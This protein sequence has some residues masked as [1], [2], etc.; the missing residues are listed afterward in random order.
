MWR[1]KRE[2]KRD[3][4][5]NFAAI[6]GFMPEAFLT[7]VIVL[8]GAYFGKK[9]DSLERKMRILQNKRKNHKMISLCVVFA[10]M[11]LAVFTV[12]SPTSIIAAGTKNS[13]YEFNVEKS[14]DG[15]E[16][17]IVGR[18]SKDTSA[19]EVKEIIGPDGESF[20]PDKVSYHVTQNGIYDFK[21]NYSS[22]TG[23]K[24]EKISVS[25]E[26]L[27]PPQKQIMVMDLKA[28]QGR[29]A[30][31]IDIPMYI[32]G[33]T[34]PREMY[35]F[36]GG[37]IK[38]IP[39]QTWEQR[40]YKFDH[41]EIQITEGATVKTYPISYYD[42]IDGIFYYAVAKDGVPAQDFDV[43]YEAPPD[44][45]VAFVYSLDTKEYTVTL[46]ND[47]K[48]EGFSVD[49]L[50]GIKTDK[51][52]NYYA[53]SMAPVKVQLTYPVGYYV[54]NAPEG[55]EAVGISFNFDDPALKPEVSSDPK[56]RIVTYAFNYPD[57]AVTMT[58]VGDKQTTDLT[59][60][61]D[62]GSPGFQNWREQGETMWTATDADGNYT[63]S[64]TRYG[65]CNNLSER[66]FDMQVL[67]GTSTPITVSSGATKNI[68]TG[69]FNSGQELDFEYVSARYMTGEMPFFMWPSPTVNFCYFPNGEDYSTGTPI[70]ETIQIWD[71]GWKVDP[72]DPSGFPPITPEPYIAG[73][74]AKITVTV[75]K[76]IVTNKKENTSL[77]PLTSY[78][79]YKV[80]VKIENMKNSFY[81]RS[82]S[83][84]SVQGP[85]Y[86]RD[87]ESISP[88]SVNGVYDSY[89]VDSDTQNNN[90]DG[91]EDGKISPKSIAPGGI[92]LDKLALYN[93]NMPDGSRVPWAGDTD[94]FFQFKIAPKW[95]Y[96]NP[97]I[98]S[99]GADST[100]IMTNV[101]IEIENEKDKHNASLPLGSYSWFNPNQNRKDVSS[102]Q[103]TMFMP[104]SS[105]TDRHDLRAI[106]VKTDKITVDITNNGTAPNSIVE[107]GSNGTTFD[108]LE[109]DK[110]IFNPDYKAS[111]EEGKTFVGF[112]GEITAPDNELLPSDYKLLLAKSLDNTVYFRPGDV[113]SLSDYFRRDA[114][115]LLDSWNNNKTLSP[116][117][118]ERLNLLMYSGN[119]KVKFNLIYKDGTSSEGEMLT[120]KVNKY[121]QDVNATDTQY[122]T[123]A[124]DTK[125][126]DIIAGSKITFT[127]FAETHENTADHYTYYHNTQTS[128]AK[129]EITTQGEELA[130]VKYDRGLTVSYLNDNK[131]P[132]EGIS[133]TNVYR[134]YDGSNKAAIK[135]PTVA[136][137]PPGKAFDHWTVEELE[138]NGQWTQKQDLKLSEGESP[139]VYDFSSG[140]GANNKSIRLTAVW[141]DI[142]PE[143][144]VSIPMNIVLTEN[145]TNLNDP[146]QKHAGSGVTISY[147][148]VYGNDKTVNVDVLKAFN[149]TSVNDASKTVAVS[150]CNADGSS[151]S[152]TAEDKY[153]NVALLGPSGA[154]GAVQTKKLWFN[155]VSQSGN[156]VYKGTFN[157][158]SSLAAGETPL[159][160]ISPG[161]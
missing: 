103:Y 21:V 83:S 157:A 114:A 43:A 126:V 28:M 146:A 143:Y 135:F 64:D 23:K 127:N 26:N 72:D 10:M 149:L 48:N 112:I 59:Y 141:K 82:Q 105:L 115:V 153:A 49:V 2:N 54:K 119:L 94:A 30:A 130:S 71:P 161:P 78:P 42:E 123:T 1:W 91:G 147:Q 152:N 39:N 67:G 118:Q 133:D 4:I 22:E 33:E 56:K 138:D 63:A 40:P 95:G 84:S 160:Y 86:F 87:I 36:A 136:Q 99:Y 148:Q 156:E 68:A 25:V 15:T 120:G 81:L 111:K 52:G 142:T 7:K 155:T 65:A 158:G 117:E 145:N 37:D 140:M 80:H 20:N 70:V 41:A 159:F 121:L 106:D 151:L 139:T 14:E 124:F 16:A 128:T 12:I 79:S 107:S 60:G 110:I 46:V 100:P 122:N 116:E 6:I 132:F 66:K 96:T 29:A 58:V 92:F 11:S 98:E 62:D 31:S 134:T 131:A 45:K 17:D 90:G 18:L 27:R 8:I 5:L 3:S 69:T 51:D 101:P 32:K 77:D 129:H 93:K 85:H 13:G 74:G 9:G 109:N 137:Y 55:Q 89:Y 113:V 53:N 125:D 76:A 38:G 24:Q 44:S 61:F 150:P 88:D 35:S 97:R 102:F 73:N 75:K 57:Q 50:S 144:F 19:G 47:K 34:N 108:L 104:V 154:S